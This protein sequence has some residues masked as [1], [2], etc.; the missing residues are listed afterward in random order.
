MPQS[1]KVCFSDMSFGELKTWRFG[2]MINES[3]K[4]TVLPA[5][6]D[7]VQVR[8]HDAQPRGAPLQE[9]GKMDKEHRFILQG[10]HATNLFF[11]PLG[12]VFFR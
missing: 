2:K 3:V 4:D 1:L 6:Y 11:P 7:Q 12:F 8:G 9:G 5:N 10:T